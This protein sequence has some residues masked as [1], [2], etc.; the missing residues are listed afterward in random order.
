MTPI[1]LDGCKGGWLAVAGRPPAVSTVIYERLEDVPAGMLVIDTPIGL[2]DDWSTPRPTDRAARK[3][4]SLLNWDGHK[5][6]GSR[7]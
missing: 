6:V 2:P 5:G 4:L 1:G 7:V 3:L